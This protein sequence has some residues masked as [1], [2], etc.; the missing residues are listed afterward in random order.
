MKSKPVPRYYVRESDMEAFQRGRGIY[1]VH[2]GG[3]KWRRPIRSSRETTKLEELQ[4][5]FQ[6]IASM[7]QESAQDIAC[8]TSYFYYINK[9]KVQHQKQMIIL[10]MILAT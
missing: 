9:N 7:E 6:N 5:N 4:A 3:R 10:K 1:D 8:Y 2:G